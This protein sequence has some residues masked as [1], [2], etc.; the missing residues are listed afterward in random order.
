MVWGIFAIFRA[1]GGSI[2]SGTISSEWGIAS[3]GGLLSGNVPGAAAWCFIG[4][5]KQARPAPLPSGT[6]SSGSVLTDN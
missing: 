5:S 4:F 6:E 1:N 2:L 3:T